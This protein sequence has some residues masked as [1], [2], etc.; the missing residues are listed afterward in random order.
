[1]SKELGYSGIEIYSGWIN[2]E[3]NPKLQFPKS[4]D[5]YD[6]MRKGDA[7]VQAILK[8]VKLPILNGNYFVTPASEDK[9]DI[10]I[11]DF[12]RDQ[13]FNKLI[14]KNFLRRILISFDFGFMIFEKVYV[15]A[16]DKIYYKKMAD[17][18]PKSVQNWLTRPE[19][20]KDVDHPGIEQNIMNDLDPAKV[21]KNVKIPGGKIFRYTIEQ[22]GE[23]YEGISLLRSA[24]KHWFF[25]DKTYK[26]EVIAA[27]RGG[28]G[29][30][31][32]RHTENTDIKPTEKSEI[33]ATLKGLRVN[34]KSY[35]IEPF[36]WEF[37]FESIKDQ[38]DFEKLINHH[39]R[40]ITKSVLAQFLELGV[41]KGALSQSKSDQNLF[42]KSIMAHV[43]MIL[44]RINRELVTEIVMMNFD[45][46]E[47]FPK[48][49]V[50][51]IEQDDIAELSAAVQRLSQTGHLTPDLK[52]ENVLRRKLKLP[53]IE[54][55]VRKK[56]V[57]D[58]DDKAKA[59]KTKD[60]EKKKTLSRDLTLFREL[61]LAEE[62]MDIPKLKKFFDTV[63]EEIVEIASKF[64]RV[65]EKQ[66]FLDAREYLKT[67]EFPEIGESITG[68]QKKIVVELRKKLLD[69]YTFGTTEAAREMDKDG[70]IKVPQTAR[71]KSEELANLYADTVTEEM[72][73]AT[74]SKVDE[75]KSNGL[76]EAAILAAVILAT[77]GVS[78]RQNSL[79]A[80]TS[81]SEM[82]NEGIVDTYDEYKEDISM[83]QYSA[84]LDDRTTEL[85]KSLDGTVV[86][87]R[88]D[89]PM[90]PVHMNC[91]PAG[92]QIITEEGEKSIEKV[93]KG[94]KV[95]T[96]ELRYE[97]VTE[98][99]ER[100]YKGELICVSGEGF[101]FECTEE[102]PILTERGWIMA[103]DVNIE[104]FII[105]I[106]Q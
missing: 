77:S 29:L 38:F 59:K 9:K 23:N 63:A 103:K 74:K 100:K 62:R 41:T 101:S 88:K 27:E 47:A 3:Y 70:R 2:E 58:D 1:M 87:E 14:F 8:A 75:E 102:H 36:G 69:S 94:E 96:H 71:A 17:R 85:C 83:Y 32:A 50:S 12:V 52:T 86:K 60:D 13:F 104:D 56:E 106:C 91:F 33:E 4:V 55:Q 78:G 39:D 98:T 54:E 81:N 46:V 90:P 43:E 37:R 40:E 10:E 6:E 42:L 11:A 7:S 73:S 35:M 82:F 80:H 26:I 28:A 24:Y 99:M 18:L 61:T 49:E 21:G 15:R 57:V 68:P 84:I 31:V 30:P 44:E 72:R 64:S 97:E 89:M 93:L 20:M 48:I 16:G 76:D 34:E 79:F 51:G 66:M 22:E 65:L 67:G 105:K 53:E 92:H 25:K 45:G 5:V 95:L 19:H